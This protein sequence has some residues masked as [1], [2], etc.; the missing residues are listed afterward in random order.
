MEEGGWRGGSRVGCALPARKHATHAPHTS[1]EQPAQGR[2][3]T[4]EARMRGRPHLHAADVQEGRDVSGAH[5]I[6]VHIPPDLRPQP[7]QRTTGKEQGGGGVR[8]A[9][10][11]V[12]CGAQAHC[13]C[14][15]GEAGCCIPARTQA[16]AASRRGEATFGGAPPAA[17]CGRGAQ[18]CS[19]GTGRRNRWRSPRR[20]KWPAQWGSGEGRGAWTGRPPRQEQRARA[21]SRGVGG[22]GPGRTDAPAQASG[23]ALHLTSD[24]LVEPCV[25]QGLKKLP[26]KRLLSQSS[27]WG[28]PRRL[29]GAICVRVGAQ[30]VKAICAAFRAPEALEL[31]HV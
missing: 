21:A 3:P 23:F 2:R 8:Q 4:G 30:P 11:V 20:K 12:V 19:A 31:R 27:R 16:D 28:L 6:A 7:R 13:G 26:S 29:L 9:S 15:C 10:Q 18:A 5:D 25:S 14:G 24:F 22:R 1:P 17:P